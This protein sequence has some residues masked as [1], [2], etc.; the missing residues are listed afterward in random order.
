MQSFKIDDAVVKK[1]LIVTLGI[2]VG[3][4]VHGR[5]SWGTARG[6]FQKKNEPEMAVRVRQE[7]RLGALWYS[8]HIFATVRLIV[9]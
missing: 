6:A 3:A 5:L 2:I 8:I 4:I 9:I 1:L 7:V